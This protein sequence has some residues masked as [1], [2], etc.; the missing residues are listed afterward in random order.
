MNSDKFFVNWQVI[1]GSD[2]ATDHPVRRVR[3]LVCTQLLTRTSTVNTVFGGGAK[4]SLHR[5]AMDSQVTGRTAQSQQTPQKVP[6]KEFN[7]GLLL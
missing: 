2:A 4:K 1:C 3:G 7:G 5:R 6:L